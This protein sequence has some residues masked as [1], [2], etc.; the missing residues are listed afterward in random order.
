MFLPYK[1]FFVPWSEL[2]LCKFLV[3]ALLTI[4]FKMPDSLSQTLQGDKEAEQKPPQSINNILPP[5]LL[6]P[7]PRPIR[8]LHLLLPDRLILP[9]DQ[10]PHITIRTVARAAFH[11]S[12]TPMPELVQIVLDAPVLAPLRSIALADLAGEDFVGRGVAR[13]ADDVAFGV[14]ELGFAHCVVSE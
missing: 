1:H 7:T 13:L 14:A 3:V 10:I 5:R 4:D 8:H 11:S 12:I 9:L 2:G 6:N